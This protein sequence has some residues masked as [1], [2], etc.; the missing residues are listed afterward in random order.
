MWTRDWLYFRLGIRANIFYRY[1]KQDYNEGE[2]FFELLVTRSFA[3]SYVKY[4]ETAKETM[5]I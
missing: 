2:K 5:S 1:F 4:Y 3:I